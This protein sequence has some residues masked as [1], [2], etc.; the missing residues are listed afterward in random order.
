MILKLFKIEWDCSSLYWH[1]LGLVLLLRSISLPVKGFYL[2]ENVRMDIIHRSLTLLQRSGSRTFVFLQVGH[3][4]Y[5]PLASTPAFCHG[6][7][8]LPHGRSCPRLVRILVLHLSLGPFQSHVCGIMSFHRH[9]FPGIRRSKSHRQSS[10]ALLTPLRRAPSQPRYL[11]ESLCLT[12]R[13][14]PEG[15][16]MD[17]EIVHLPLRFRSAY[18]E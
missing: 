17:P 8:H 2:F 9:H 4:R 14:Y 16:R 10:N 18:R 7:D 11:P 6:I 13:L 12:N 1:Y 3:V 15:F 5:H